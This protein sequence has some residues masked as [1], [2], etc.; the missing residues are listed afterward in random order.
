MHLISKE[1][2]LCLYF[3]DTKKNVVIQVAEYSKW[4]FVREEIGIKI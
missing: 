3:Q 1:S 2:S 4:N